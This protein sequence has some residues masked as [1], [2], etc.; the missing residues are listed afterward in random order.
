MKGRAGIIVIVG[1][2]VILA[3]APACQ[4]LIVKSPDSDLNV[5]DFEAA[6]SAIDS[7]YSYLEFKQID[8]DSIYT[9]FR[10]RAEAARGDE[11]I[12]VLHDLLYQLR[13]AH[14]YYVTPGGSRIYPWISPRRLRD[15]DLYNPF[16]VRK[17]FDRDL[18][19]SPS[20][21]IEYGI[22]PDNIGYIFLADFN[23]DY[24]SRD[25]YSVLRSLDTT[26]GLII[27]IRQRIDHRSLIGRGGGNRSGSPKDHIQIG[28]DILD[29][30]TGEGAAPLD[31]P[32]RHG[33]PR[34]AVG[35]DLRHGG[36]Y[37]NP[38]KILEV[39]A[40]PSA[41]IQAVAHRT[42]GDI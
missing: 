8:W 22:L 26:S 5:E 7:D 12:S 40:H 16:V 33:A 24:L 30:L 15:Q 36:F 37:L 35:D 4:N 27:D 13:D 23:E 21:K 14:A 1:L 3:G 20:G 28:D 31:A 34:Y 6:W 25:F 32:G 18:K 39:G 29:I 11:F 19:R 10:P 41:T 17:Y 9:E 2:M 38:G 42:I